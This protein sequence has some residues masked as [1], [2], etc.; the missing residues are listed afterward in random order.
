MVEKTEILAFYA[1][2]SF[3]KL[4][5]LILANA[6]QKG[7]ELEIV[8]EFDV[9]NN[10]EYLCK[11]GTGENLNLDGNKVKYLPLDIK[12]L[13]F[14][15]LYPNGRWS[16]SEPVSTMYGDYLGFT[17]TATIYNGAEI[18]AEQSNFFAYPCIKE[19]EVEVEKKNENS[20]YVKT[21]ELRYYQYPFL[22]TNPDKDKTS[23]FIN[24]VAGLQG[25][26]LTRAFAN[27]GI[28]MYE[29]ES[30]VNDN[31]LSTD[32]TSSEKAKEVANTPL[33]TF[34]NTFA[35]DV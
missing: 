4:R 9:L 29:F 32:G 22:P 1:D 5:D 23:C 21:K 28:G 30:E 15:M 12:K 34:N 26:C 6:K 3:R 20:E 24:A 35:E 16:V 31:V 18:L 19:I 17:V 7:E 11:V 14:R 33:T 8:N 10:L 2:Q 13:V 27:L 25:R